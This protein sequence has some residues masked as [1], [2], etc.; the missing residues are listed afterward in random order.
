MRPDDIIRVSLQV[1]RQ[2]DRKHGT[3]ACEALTRMVANSSYS[4]FLRLEMRDRYSTVASKAELSFGILNLELCPTSF[5]AVYTRLPRERLK[6]CVS[7]NT[8]I[9]HV[10]YGSDRTRLSAC[11]DHRVSFA[12]GFIQLVVVKFRAFLLVREEIDLVS[13]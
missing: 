12:C 10:Q 1:R 2:I 7:C 5:R 6:V 13:P 4:N 8:Q 9:V 11:L 3:K